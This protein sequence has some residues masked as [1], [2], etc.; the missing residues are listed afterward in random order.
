MQKL[1]LASILVLAVPSFSSSVTME[2]VTVGDPGNAPDSLNTN[3]VPGIGA[4]DYVYQIGKFEV[5]NSEYAEFLNSVAAFGDTY[6]LYNLSM[7]SDAHASISR[8]G[9]GIVDDPYVYSSKPNM[10]NKPVNYV[11]FYDAVRFVNWLENGQ[12]TGTNQVAGV[13]ETGS[14][15]LFTSGASTTNVSARAANATWVLPDENEWYKAAYYDPTASGTT[16]YWLYPT[17]SDLA[18]TIASVDGT[19]DISNPGENVANYNRGLALPDEGLTSVG[20]AGLESA[21]HYGTFDQGGNAWEWD[22]TVIV[23]SPERRGLRGGGWAFGEERMQSSDRTHI[24]TDAE[25]VFIGFRVAMIPEPSC[26]AAIWIALVGLAALGVRR[27][28]RR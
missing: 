14:Y 25:H 17:Q 24:D 19:G 26:V 3:A 5:Q 20:S 23:L 13:T 28:R 11:S 18:P 10:G 21:S 6:G 15:T 16:N 8:T 9:S 2:M 1:V 22:E 4:V 12:P 27:R 7:D